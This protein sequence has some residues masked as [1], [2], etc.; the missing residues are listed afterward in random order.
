M[1]A[2]TVSQMPLFPAEGLRFPLSS[3][4]CTLLALIN[5]A[6]GLRPP[7]RSHNIIPNSSS[8]PR[9]IGIRKFFKSFNYFASSFYSSIASY[10]PQNT[11]KSISSNGCAISTGVQRHHLHHICCLFVPF[12]PPVFWS[13]FV[14]TPPRVFGLFVAWKLRRQTKGEF[15]S[16]NRTQKGQIRSRDHPDAVVLIDVSKIA[17]TRQAYHS[18]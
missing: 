1:I 9:Q 16:S 12:A 14:L 15:L 18:P 8:I 5:E 7:P 17:D 13:R 2:V 11:A 4:L 10:T 3:I 6:W